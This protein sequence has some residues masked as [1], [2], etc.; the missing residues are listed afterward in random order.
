[1]SENEDFKVGP[2]DDADDVVSMHIGRMA[3]THS[4][5]FTKNINKMLATHAP[6]EANGIMQ[7]RR[8]WQAHMSL[9]GHSFAITHYMLTQVQFTW[10]PKHEKH[11]LGRLLD[12]A[13]SIATQF[14]QAIIDAER[15]QE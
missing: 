14:Y 1:M 8:L 2:M 9:V 6:D 13:K 5:Q 4:R 11:K 7:I 12:Q 15:R 3:E 10:G